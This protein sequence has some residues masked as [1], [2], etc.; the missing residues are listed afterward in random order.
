MYTILGAGLSGLSV[1]DHFKKQSVA[2]KLFEAKS[3]GG[4]HIYSEKTDKFTWDEGPPCFVY[5]I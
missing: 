4:G 5:Q 1:A 2:F 3:H